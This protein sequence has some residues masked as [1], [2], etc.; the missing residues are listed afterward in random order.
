MWTLIV[1]GDVFAEMSVVLQDA[2]SIRF[3]GRAYPWPGLNESFEIN[4]SPGNVV[5]YFGADSENKHGRV[6]RYGPRIITL[7]LIG[8]FKLN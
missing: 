3:A 7:C 4:A 1:I 5:L 6:V 8:V 2:P